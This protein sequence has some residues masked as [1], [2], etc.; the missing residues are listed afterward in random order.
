MSTLSFGALKSISL[1]CKYGILCL[2]FG[3]SH[4]FCLE[5]QVVVPCIVLQFPP[6]EE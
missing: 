5:V 1:Y 2:G 6:S 4:V 3:I